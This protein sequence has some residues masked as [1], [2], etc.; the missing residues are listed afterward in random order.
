VVAGLTAA[1]RG[2]LSAGSTDTRCPIVSGGR[3]VPGSLHGRLVSPLN[4]EATRINLSAQGGGLLTVTSVADVNAHWQV[5]D[6][7]NQEVSRKRSLTL[8][9]SALSSVDRPQTTYWVA[10]HD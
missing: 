9:L 2:C 8:T 3:P 1:L 5:W 7:N 10:N 4:L 6:F